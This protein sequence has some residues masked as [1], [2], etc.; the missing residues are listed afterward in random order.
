MNAVSD[1]EGPLVSCAL[2]PAKSLIGWL[3][4]S[5]TGAMRTAVG[6]DTPPREYTQE[7][8]AATMS[9]RTT[10][11]PRTRGTGVR[12]RRGEDESRTPEAEGRPRSLRSRMATVSKFAECETNERGKV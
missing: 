10:A 2:K 12:T 5:P 4:A 7:P 3:S 11:I 8:R 6:P 9:E 1:Q